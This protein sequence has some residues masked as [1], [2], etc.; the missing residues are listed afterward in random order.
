VAGHLRHTIASSLGLQPGIPVVTGA[1]DQATGLLGS[2]IVSPNLLAATIGT[3]GQLVTLLNEPRADDQLRTH[4]FCHAVPEKW[5]LLGA[6]LSAGLAFRWLRDSVLHESADGGYDRMVNQAAEVPPGAEGLL[7]LPYLVG[8][9]LATQSSQAR[10]MYFGLNMRHDQSHMIRACMEGVIFSLRRI[11]DI[12]GEIGV[13]PKQIIASGGGTR[14]ELWCQIMAD[15][16]QSPVTP[17]ADQEQSA[18]GAVILAGLG[19]GLFED[20]RQACQTF[21]SY[22]NSIEPQLGTASRYQQGYQQFCQLYSSTSKLAD[23]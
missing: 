14:S 9:R 21:V 3:G 13:E 15:V 6:T 16:F 12:F 19:I 20:T 4:T 1:S 18:V 10:G 5:Y 22:Q 17:L 23:H 11:F 8:E 7:F 2:G